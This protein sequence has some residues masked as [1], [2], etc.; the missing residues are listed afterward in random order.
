MHNSVDENY[1]YVNKTEICKLKVHVNICW[2]EFCLGTILKDFTKDE[3]SETSLNGTIYDFLVDHSATE[4]E[5]IL[6]LIFMNIKWKIMFKFIK[7]A[8][9]VLLSFGGSLA[10]KCILW[11]Y[12]AWWVRT[13]FIYLN[14]NQLHFL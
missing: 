11:N 5:D 6:Y 4:K 12:E 9:I 13:T 10:T 14:R 2:H 1:L 8:F 7:Q 3:M